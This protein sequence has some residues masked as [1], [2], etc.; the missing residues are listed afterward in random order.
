MPDHMPYYVLCVVGFVNLRKFHSR[1]P[2]VGP[3]KG[4]YE[5]FCLK[6]VRADHRAALLAPTHELIVVLASLTFISWPWEVSTTQ[7]WAVA[8][9]AQ[10]WGDIPCLTEIGVCVVC[11]VTPRPQWL[12]CFLLGFHMKSEGRRTFLGVSLL[13]S[14]QQW[15]HRGW[16]TP[17]KQHGSMLLQVSLASISM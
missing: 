7:L 14:P 1:K 3:I 9:V 17:R 4:Q 5:R 13:G 12:M 10:S 15:V 8:P 16:F 11:G 6:W 2:H